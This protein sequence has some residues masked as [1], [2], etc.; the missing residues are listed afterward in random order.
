MHVKR[1]ALLVILYFLFLNFVS[2]EYKSIVYKNNR[3]IEYDIQFNVNKSLNSSVVPG[4]L[5]CM[6]TY[7]Y[8]K[9]DSMFYLNKVCNLTN[10]LINIL[11]E[12]IK[13]KYSISKF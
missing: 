9:C 10:C 3:Q 13:I 12:G 2:S 1:I 8:G 6:I 11:A 7:Q 4:Q 5:K